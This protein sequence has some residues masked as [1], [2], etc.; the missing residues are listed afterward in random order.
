MQQ[1]RRALHA[2]TVIVAI[3]FGNQAVLMGS[4]SEDSPKSTTNNNQQVAPVTVPVG[5]I[6][7]GTRWG[8]DVVKKC[9][10]SEK[11]ALVM[12]TVVGTVLTVIAHIHDNKDQEDNNFFRFK[13]ADKD[14]K[15]DLKAL[16]AQV[17]IENAIF[18]APEIV[19][20]IKSCIWSAK[21]KEAYD[22]CHSC[23]T[24]KCKNCGS[25][26]NPAII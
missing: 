16:A 1:K 15:V 6:A 24:K 9:G 3:A 12:G 20:K 21:K 10:L 7:T 13:V 5:F 23:H 14:V 8:V 4:D 25:S 22:E 11:K 19:S 18:H 26:L 17:V 2:I